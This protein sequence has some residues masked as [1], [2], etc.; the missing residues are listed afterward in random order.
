M[1]DNSI[2]EEAV[3]DFVRGVPAGSVVTYGQVAGLVVGVSLTP[4]QVGG[5]MAHCP[6]DAPWHRVVGAGGY[7]PIG[8]RNPEWKEEQRRRLEEEGVVFLANGCVDMGRFE[9][10]SEE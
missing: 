5:I 3:F 9:M 7:L 6:P 10:R 8:K 2:F 1:K 4:R